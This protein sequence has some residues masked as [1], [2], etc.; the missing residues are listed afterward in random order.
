[1]ITGEGTER[2]V[3][4]VRAHVA[5]LLGPALVLLVLSP[6][7]GYSLARAP[8]GWGRGVVAVIAAVLA[9]RL[10][11]WP[12]LQWWTTTYTVTTRRLSIR[13]GVLS[14]HARDVPLHR[15]VDVSLQRSPAQRL[16]GSGTIAVRTDDG[17]DPILLAN[18]PRARRVHAAM[19]ALA[20]TEEP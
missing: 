7:A 3:V 15:V 12:F 20:G 2:L 19:T 9:A 4:E 16:V 6:L 5:G 14:R 18:L 13:W 11:F 1:M 8:S 17:D 10:A